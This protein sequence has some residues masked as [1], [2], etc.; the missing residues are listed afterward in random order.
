[1]NAKARH[2]QTLGNKMRE[3]FEIFR[4]A[5]FA[6]VACC[7]LGSIGPGYANILKLQ[8][9]K[10]FYAKKICAEWVEIEHEFGIQEDITSFHNAGQ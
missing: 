2:Q 7:T 8:S 4:V 5:F 1:M 6:F 9:E 3:F 10:V